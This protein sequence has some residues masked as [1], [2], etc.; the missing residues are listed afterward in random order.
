M[1]N[2]VTIVSQMKYST[3]EIYDLAFEMNI[4]TGTYVKNSIQ[5]KLIKIY[6]RLFRS[7]SIRR[8]HRHCLKFLYSS[9]TFAFIL[10][11]IFAFLYE[12]FKKKKTYLLFSISK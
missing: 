1:M 11:D 8:F 7:P 5:T 10:L 3:S 2:K 4:L 12:Y 6:A 9:I